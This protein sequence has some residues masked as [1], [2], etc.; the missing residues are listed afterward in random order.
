M[1]VE[2]ALQGCQPHPRM[3]APPCLRHGRE[4]GQQRRGVAEGVE[5]QLAEGSESLTGHHMAVGGDQTAGVQE[6]GVGGGCGSRVRVVRLPVVLQPAV[7]LLHQFG[8]KRLVLSPEAAEFSTWRPDGRRA[9][10]GCTCGEGLSRPAACR[11][12]SS[13]LLS[14]PPLWCFSSPTTASTTPLGL[15]PPRD[16]A[17][18]RATGMACTSPPPLFLV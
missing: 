15:H 7:D 5:G 18:A 12:A 3:R 6:P 4:Q 10:G 9:E 13:Q 2:E 1:E 11:R 8:K 17:E 14:S 16:R